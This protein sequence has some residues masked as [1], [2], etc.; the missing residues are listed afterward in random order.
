MYFI[1]G[2]NVSPSL[3]T[4]IYISEND[5]KSPERTAII[6]TW[7]TR[8]KSLWETTIVYNGVCGLILL[9]ESQ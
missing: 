5:D 1:T 9:N 7:V 4:L 8:K 6:I 2:K 3:F